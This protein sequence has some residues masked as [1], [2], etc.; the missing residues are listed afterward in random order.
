M[1][2]PTGHPNSLPWPFRL[3]IPR[4]VC[5][6]HLN[7]DPQVY[8]TPM[9]RDRMAAMIFSGTG[10]WPDYSKLVLEWWS[11]DNPVYQELR[12]GREARLWMR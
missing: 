4:L 12:G 11:S 5:R 8:F 9:G 10:G 7:F 3:E 1:F 6:Q 2:G